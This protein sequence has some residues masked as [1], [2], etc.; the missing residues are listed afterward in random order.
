MREAQATELMDLVGSH[1]VGLISCLSFE[2]RSLSA[3]KVL[4]GRGLKRWFAFENLDVETSIARLTTEAL[5]AADRHDVNFIRLPWSKK[6]PLIL[7]DA[8]VKL[9]EM[10]RGSGLRWV[11]DI[12]TM[13]H[14][15]VLVLVA[16]IEELSPD[17][18]DALIVYNLAAD[19]S[20]NEADREKK[21]ISR[22]IY[23]VRSVIGYSGLWNLGEPAVLVALPG[24]DLE[25]VQRIIEEVE[26]EA[27]IVGVAKPP[28][29][30]YK[31]MYERN[32]SV[33]NHLLSTRP[34]H[35]FEY[36]S[37]VAG[38]A[39][40]SIWPL[41]KDLS[42]NI[43]IAPLNTKFST[44][45][46]GILARQNPRWQILYAPPLVYNLNYSSP[47]EVFLCCSFSEVA[48]TVKGLQPDSLRV[49]CTTE[50]VN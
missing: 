3:P 13:T 30:R 17:W 41:V 34:G 33:A 24:F 12:S 50:A 32:L 18:G 26:P 25:R 42:C 19:Y 23:G 9:V 21:W 31:W 16:A 20:P 47:S 28:K 4:A 5:D 6:D 22:G 44:L 43:L 1:P 15:M 11:I 2:S 49:D 48:E 37:L 35:I 45:S 39:A 7:A 10:S 40:R 14:E 8:A 27:L 36:D 29:P 38:D 46:I